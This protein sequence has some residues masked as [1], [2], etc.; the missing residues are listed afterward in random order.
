MK[1]QYFGKPLTMTKKYHVKKSSTISWICKKAYEEGEMKVKDRDHIAGK[2]RRSAHQGC[3]LNL[4]LSKKSSVVFHN[5]SNFD[6]HLILQDV[7]K[8]NFKYML[9]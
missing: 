8:Y 3:Y 9:Y 4:S 1:I 7:G 6:S 5:F 2:Y